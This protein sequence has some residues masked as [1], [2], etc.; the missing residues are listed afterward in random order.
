MA[1]V[2]ETTCKLI[3]TVSE[4]ERPDTKSNFL[5]GKNK[6]DNANMRISS[7][8]LTLFW[9]YGFLNENTKVRYLTLGP[10]PGAM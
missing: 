5:K 10:G 9:S 6:D 2:R 4:F 7:H 8:N 1:A 3:F